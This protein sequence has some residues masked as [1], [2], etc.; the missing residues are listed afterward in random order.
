[1]GHLNV[2]TVGIALQTTIAY[3]YGQGVRRCETCKNQMCKCPMNNGP[4]KL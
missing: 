1:M 3:D 2:Q 4:R